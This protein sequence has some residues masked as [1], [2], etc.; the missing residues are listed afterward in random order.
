MKSLV[1]LLLLSQSLQAE[2]LS[3]TDIDGIPR[4]TANRVSL[5]IVGRLDCVAFD[6]M[7]RRELAPFAKA[8]PDFFSAI[9]FPCVDPLQSQLREWRLIIP[10]ATNFCVADMYFANT[11]LIRFFSMPSGT[12]AYATFVY[13]S[14][15]QCLFESGRFVYRSWLEP[16]LRI[17]RSAGP[18]WNSIY[19][20]WTLVTNTSQPGCTF[21]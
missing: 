17:T 3:F 12:P 19:L 8:N 16:N 13:N 10:G 7:V 11:N 14:K 20:P 6:I 9:I 21:F 15:G 2:T 4:S 5:I 18:E 1:L